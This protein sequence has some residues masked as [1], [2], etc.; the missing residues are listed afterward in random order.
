[1]SLYITHGSLLQKST[2]ELIKVKTEYITASTMTIEPQKHFIFFLKKKE[3]KLRPA[4]KCLDFSLIQKLEPLL[5]AKLKYKYSD[6]NMHSPL[7]SS[8]DEAARKKTLK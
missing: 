6:I 8:D 5:E 4:E 2:L 7:L 3:D 1:M